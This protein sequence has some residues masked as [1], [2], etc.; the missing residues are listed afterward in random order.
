MALP[1]YVTHG[2]VAWY[3]ALR[4]ICGLV[5]LFLILPILAIIPLSFNSSTFLTYPLRGWSMRW[6]A[7]IFSDQRWLQPLR[8][9]LLVA[10]VTTVLATILGTLAA[11][12]LVR[13]KERW[14]GLVM[15][16][17]ISPMIIRWSSP[18]S[19]P[20]SCSLRWA[21]RTPSPAWYWHTPLLRCRSWW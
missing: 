13:L 18:P 8:N 2:E 12:G 7:E 19:A 1:S 9:S 11:L 3:W 6:Y 20:T 17:L 21:S 15:A 14:R 10:S 16:A 5:L 4:L